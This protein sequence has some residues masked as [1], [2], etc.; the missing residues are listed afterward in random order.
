[1]TTFTSVIAPSTTRLPDLSP[2]QPSVPLVSLSQRAQ[3]INDPDV[4]LN[5]CPPYSIPPNAQDRHGGSL[6]QGRNAQN[7]DTAQGQLVP[8]RTRQPSN[9]VAQPR[10]T[11]LKTSIGDADK[12]P[13]IL[14][15]YPALST[16]VSSDDD[17]F[18]VRR[19]EK[20]G[21]R[22]ILRMQDRIA[23]LEEELIEQDK[24]AREKNLDSGTFR[25]EPEWA[26]RQQ[27][28]NELSWRLREYQ[29]F[30]LDHSQLKARPDASAFQI[31]NLRTWLKNSN[32]PIEPEEVRFIDKDGDL[33]PVVPKQRTPLR[34]FMD[35]YQ[36]LRN[37]ICFRQRK[38]N[39]SH[40]GH[41]D[42]ENFETNTTIYTRDTTINKFVTCT[43]I[44]LGLAMLVG[45]LWVL[46]YVS[47]AESGLHNR[48]TVITVFIIAFTIMISILTVATPFETLA[49]TAAY[50]AVLMVYMQLSN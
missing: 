27:I 8:P 32:K 29:Q 18:V 42:P 21:A 41:E 37:L 11:T 24:L 20:L 28:M 5:I 13:R 14:R 26:P 36:L 44:L 10:A 19:F 34:R 40:F 15:G 46:Q 39:Q 48:L 30:V 35:R 38:L 23:Y 9:G 25:Y 50:G 43:T 1:M 2:T 31:E 6:H 45:P 22:V 17:L 49:A 3:T 33:M 12:K 16:F 7:A 4:S 47:T